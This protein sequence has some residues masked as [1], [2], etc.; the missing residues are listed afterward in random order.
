MNIIEQIA[1]RTALDEQIEAAGQPFLSAL[2][3]LQGPVFTAA[4]RMNVIGGGLYHA[5]FLGAHVDGDRIVFVY[6]DGDGDQSSI[7]LTSEQ[8]AAG[9]D[10]LVAELYAHAAERALR[11]EENRRAAE[12]D[13]EKRQRAEYERLR[14]LYDA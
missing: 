14:L 3:K 12:A 11:D 4:R 5:S 1:Q 6:R 8:F 13:A 7:C 9:P 10:A 2:Q